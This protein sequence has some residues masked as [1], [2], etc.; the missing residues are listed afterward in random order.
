VCARSV[1]PGAGGA[2]SAGFALPAALF[3]LIVIAALAAGAFFAALQ[4]VRIGRNSRRGEA[5]FGAAEAGLSRAL[6]DGLAGGWGAMRVG[7][8]AAF[9]GSLPAGTGRF[10]GTVLRLNG[11]LFLIR[12]TGSD[13]AGESQR[14]VATLAR[15]GASKGRLAAALAARGP[16]EIDGSSL[17]DGR[18]TSPPGWTDCPAAGSDTVA[19]LTVPALADLL[20]GAGCAGQSCIAGAPPV[21]ETAAVGGS[22]LLRAGEWDWP[23]LARLAA[24][25]YP[26]G[27]AGTPVTP[28]PAGTD[29][30]CD[31][32]AP[33][34]WGEPA[35]PA[36]VAA[37]RGYFPVILA[38]G[39][40]TIAG[41]R[42]Q[43]VLL[44]AGDLTVTG[45]A[46]F[47]GPVL[48]RGSLRAVGAGA[49][50]YGGVVA[51]NQGGGVSAHLEGVSITYS[52]CALHAA[53]GPVAPVRALRER[54]W[55]DLF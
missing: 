5:A 12:S 46:E 54:A 44:V 13:A 8:S 51:A 7:D 38:N 41:G 16:V 50:F 33:G 24:K 37:C 36:A 10:A 4:E 28:A 11:Q 15:L 22:A 55:A 47:D 19:G 35:R 32:S 2:V 26:A 29:S 45:G 31:R 48:V 52:G 30:L 39:D 14:S 20:P 9:A 17:L 42:G 53:L 49:R 23:T 43:G 34:N 6:A 21:L 40:L 27:G 25:I 1:L 18:D 3:S